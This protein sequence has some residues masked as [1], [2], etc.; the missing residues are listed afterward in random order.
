V[1]LAEAMRAKMGRT[2]ITRV[3]PRAAPAREQ[4]LA[5]PHLAVL[6]VDVLEAK[7]ELDH[8]GRSYLSADR[9]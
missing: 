1:I 2:Q 3:S 6:V 7:A 8:R 9:G 5:S 4:D